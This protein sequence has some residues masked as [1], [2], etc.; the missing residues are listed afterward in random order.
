MHKLPQP[1]KLWYVGSYFRRERP[2][3]GRYRQ[4]WQVGVEALGSNDPA[5]DAEV[6]LL[7]AELLEAVGVRG[8][9][10]RLGSLGTPGDARDLPRGAPG[11]PAR[12]RGRARAR[13]P[14]AD[15]PQPAARLRLRPCGDA[16]GHGGRPAAARPPRRRGRGALRGRAGAARRARACRSRSTRRS[17]AASTTT[18]ARSSSSPR[19]ALGAQSGVGGGGRYDGLVELHRRARRRRGWA[20]PRAWSGCCSPGSA[21]RSPRRRSRS[22]SPTRSRSCARPPSGSPPTCARAGHAARVELGGRSLKGQLKQADRGGRPLRCHPRRRR[23]GAEGHGVRRAAHGRARRRHALHPS[24][25][26]R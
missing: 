15:R 2:Q 12:A 3:E 25:D 17:C 1:V 4:F 11:V 16:A 21:R 23:R 8:A 7:L 10:L 13:G 19:D 24:P 20:G 9:R 22:T 14:R 6:I 26:V 5:V 18:R